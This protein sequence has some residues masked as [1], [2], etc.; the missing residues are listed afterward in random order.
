MRGENETELPNPE[1]FKTNSLFASD[2]R[3]DIES[4]LPSNGVTGSL[5]Q[6]EL[7]GLLRSSRRRFVLWYLRRVEESVSLGELAERTAAWEN[8]KDISALGSDERKRAYVALYQCHLPKLDEADIIDFDQDRKRV[9]VGSN[10]DLVERATLTSAAP[11]TEM[12]SYAPYYLLLA[13]SS[14]LLLGGAMS[15]SGPFD[16]AVIQLAFGLIGAYGLLAAWDFL[17]PIDETIDTVRSK[18]ESVHT[19]GTGAK[20][21]S[22]DEPF[23][24]VGST[25]RSDD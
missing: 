7:Y 8:E 5:S 14:I 21:G 1:T 25:R 22:S 16:T 12:T 17:R 10:Y 20:S 18:L 3:S 6:S 4:G 15:L 2:E 11:E 13:V 9:A 23:D 19:L 24:Q